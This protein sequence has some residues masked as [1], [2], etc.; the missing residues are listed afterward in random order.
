[1]CDESK[2]CVALDND[3]RNFRRFLTDRIGKLYRYQCDCDEYSRGKLVAYQTALDYFDL[4]L[5]DGYAADDD[6]D[7]DYEEV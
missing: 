1:M 4:Y 2:F 5:Y 6:L 3:L 7:D